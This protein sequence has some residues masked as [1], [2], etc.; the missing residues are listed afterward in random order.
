[1]SSS[2]SRRS[3]TNRTRRMR[4]SAGRTFVSLA[5]SPARL[6]QCHPPRFHCLVKVF[7]RRPPRRIGWYR[8]CRRRKPAWEPTFIA[9]QQSAPNTRIGCSLLLA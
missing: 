9:V 4:P 8:R 2:R 7:G 6:D 5:A 1:M 3:P